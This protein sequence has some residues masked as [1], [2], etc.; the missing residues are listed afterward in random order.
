M[1]R[2]FDIIRE[3]LA[4][5]TNHCH[6]ADMRNRS[7]RTTGVCC[8]EGERCEQP[9]KLLVVG[10]ESTFPPEIVGYALDMASR[11]SY[12]ILALNTAPLS[13]ETFMRF[14]A[15]RKKVCEDFREISAHNAK[16]FAGE[17]AAR[18]I[19]FEH[20]IRFSA[21]DEAIAEIRREWD[22][23]EFVISDSAEE[24]QASRPEQEQ[25]VQKPIFVYAMI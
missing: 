3:K 24:R 25:H 13:C 11:L 10:R 12:E 1:A 14:S 22:G 2:I 19:P 7:G 15:S 8:P 20:I 21:A 9:G 16:I 6:H 18:Q 23:V 17:A 5:K 4:G